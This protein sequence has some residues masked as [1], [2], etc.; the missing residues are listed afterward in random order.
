MTDIFL[1]YNREDQRQAKLFADAFAAAGL[2]VW[3][4]TALRSGEAYDEVTEAALRAA[5]AV[6]V[7]WSPRS[8]VSRWV[9]AEA[10]IADRCKTLVPVTIEP[11]ERPIM[12]ELTQTADLSHWTGEPGDKV[13]AALLDD[14]RRY[15]G[16]EAEPEEIAITMAEPLPRPTGERGSAPSLAVLPFTNRSQLAEDDILAEGMVEDLIAALAQGVFVRVLGGMATANLSRATI[17]DPAA[18]GRRLGVRYLLEGN[19]RRVASNLRVTTQLIEAES[20]E[21]LSTGRFDRPLD[22]LAELQEDLVHEVAGSLDTQVMNL[23]VARVLKKPGDLTAWESAMRCLSYASH[24]DAASLA[25]G[26]EE[27]RRAVEIDPEYALGHA[28]LANCSGVFYLLAFIEDPSQVKLIRRHI[29]RALE[30][31]PNDAFVLTYVGAALVYSGQLEES[32]R[33][34]A[35][36]IAKMPGNGMAQFCYSAACSWLDR[37]KEAQ[38]HGNLA[39][40]LMPGSPMFWAVMAMQANTAIRLGC[41]EDALAWLDES[42]MLNPDGSIIRL[43]QAICYRHF[44]RHGDAQAAF[45]RVCDDGWTLAQMELWFRRIMSNNAALEEHLESI[46]ALWAKADRSA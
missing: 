2:S 28:A 14:V 24:L 30:L 8:V 44:G 36:A 13:W 1:S 39:V 29:D 17:S 23:E 33:P 38:K 26:L 32:L 4:D 41:W 19:V 31:A 15:V 10:T 43:Q 11:C 7:L 5:K 18:L 9:R 42:L 34:L 20:G 21:V 22:E 12:F 16:R 37:T 25:K 35:R 27:G 3:W 45:E 40:R 46:N 6:V